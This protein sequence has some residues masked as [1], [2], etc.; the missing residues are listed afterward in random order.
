[1][2]LWVATRRRHV[3]D[4]FPTPA[5]RSRMKLQAE[6]KCF[7]GAD[8]GDGDLHGIGASQQRD[9]KEEDEDRRDLKEEDK[10]QL[11]EKGI[12]RKKTA[13][14][15]EKGVGRDWASSWASCRTR[16]MG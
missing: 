3:H 14:E 15:R 5:C 8:V 4:G 6:G 9:L 2:K 16:P 11:R 10:K 1:M 12:G 13:A 7:V